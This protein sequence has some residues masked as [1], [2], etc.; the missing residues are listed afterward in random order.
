[1]MDSLESGGG[2]RV[3]PPDFCHTACDM[4]MEKDPRSGFA[5][6][7]W[8][9]KALS[10][11]YCS[12]PG[13]S[14]ARTQFQE[15]IAK[16][17]QPG[18]KILELG[19]GPGSP[20]SRFLATLGE[21][22][23]LDIDPDVK[24]NPYC[25]KPIVYD[26]LNIPCESESFDAVVASYVAEHIEHPLE[27]CREIHRVLRSGHV[28][29]FR[30]PN[31][32]HYVSLVAKLTPMWF[33]RLVSNQLRC[34]PATAHE[35]WATYYRMNTRRACRRILT[36]AGFRISEIRCIETLPSYGVSCR[37]MFYPLMAWERFLNSTP[38]LEGL[39]VN[40]LCAAVADKS[41]H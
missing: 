5:P 33:H 38:L 9:Y 30:T 14:D 16:Y 27:V 8:Q 22:T 18:S 24:K 35:P 20:T 6:Q 11:Y 36:N 13:W 4:S 21:V 1:M 26:G 15:F 32:W 31:L 28:Y 39:R 3:L 19:A 29:I 40:I 34:L 41:R 25:H 12:C 37:L 10:K 2:R 17:V 23:G 7:S